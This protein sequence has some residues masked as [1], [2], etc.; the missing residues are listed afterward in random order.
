M[1]WI[2]HLNVRTVFSKLDSF[3]DFLLESDYDVMVVSQIWLNKG[4]ETDVHMNI[5]IYLLGEML[6]ALLNSDSNITEQLNLVN[7][8]RNSKLLISD[9]YRLPKSRVMDFVGDIHN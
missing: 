2:V 9:V 7:N 6:T 1:I 4:T 5:L 3:R 8:A